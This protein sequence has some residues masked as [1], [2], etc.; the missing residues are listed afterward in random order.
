MKRDIRRAGAA[1]LVAGIVVG[2]L[3]GCNPSRWDWGYDDQYL[4]VEN[5]KD[6]L[7]WYPWYLPGEDTTL[8][9]SGE[10][11][12][13]M[14]SGKG[15]ETTR[16][17][18][19]GAWVT[20]E[21]EGTL[22]NGVREGRWSVQS[23]DGKYDGYGYYKGGKISGTFRYTR[24]TGE[25]FEAIAIGVVEGLTTVPPILQNANTAIQLQRQQEAERRR[26]EAQRQ[27]E[28]A[29]AQQQQYEQQAATQQ[30]QYEQQQAAAQ[31]QADEYE[32]QQREAERQAERQR[33]EAERQQREAQKLAE[34]Q[35]KDAQ[36]QACIDRVSGTRN[37]CVSMGKWIG[38]SA[39]WRLHN[40][41]GD[42]INV[43]VGANDGR[44]LTASHSIKPYGYTNTAQGAGRREKGLAWQACY[45]TGGMTPTQTGCKPQSWLCAGGNP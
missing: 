34:K 42:P 28:Q 22:V 41:C 31:Q 30:Q 44:R 29:R 39:G 36:R 15:I 19:G 2:L 3:A 23:S 11:V 5:H 7:I 35:A 17:R 13:G 25:L 37:H 40:R 12:D 4:E 26:V 9:W 21:W 14:A 43:L 24:D 1:G 18:R 6:C 38:G 20:E 8:S 33:Q 10:C 32:R 45:H 27:A 16:F